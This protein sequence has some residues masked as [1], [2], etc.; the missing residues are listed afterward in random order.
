MTSNVCKID[1]GSKD[2]E[3]ILN[4]SEKVAVY[5]DLTKKQT[6]QLR[7]LCE[8][9]DGMLPN[10]VDEFEGALWIEFEDGVCKVHISIALAEITS[11]RKREL[12]DVAKNKKNAAVSGI[13][14]KIRA[15]VEDYFLKDEKISTYDMSSGFYGMA[16][17]GCIGVD[18][19]YLWTLNQYKT[20]VK[21]DARAEDWDELEKSI[22]ASIADDVIVSVKGKKVKIVIIKEFKKEN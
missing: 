10:I 3:A 1:N 18:Y 8:E 16:T 2:L 11:S 6:L 22:I 4:E 9:I 13:G 17:S 19:T 12:I 20:T 7:L 15:A 5:N 14:G 21:D